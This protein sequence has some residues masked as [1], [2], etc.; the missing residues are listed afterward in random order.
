MKKDANARNSSSTS[1]SNSAN[2][3][4]WSWGIQTQ[5][6]SCRFH[7]CCM[8]LCQALSFTRDPK[9]ACSQSHTSSISPCLD[10]QRQEAQFQQLS[11]FRVSQSKSFSAPES[12]QLN[13]AWLKKLSMNLAAPL[14]QME[15]SNSAVSLVV[16]SPCRIRRSRLGLKSINLGLKSQWMGS[17]WGCT[18]PSKRL[19]RQSKVKKK[20]GQTISSSPRVS[21][22]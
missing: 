13:Q 21:L 1:S 2:C 10:W 6:L 3:R 18:E 17:V 11:S 22:L 16:M 12:P 14:A 20:H 15:V 4:L 5:W 8:N 7:S 19:A 9:W